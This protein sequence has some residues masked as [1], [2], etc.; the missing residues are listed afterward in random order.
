MSTEMM[1]TTIWR[2]M[3]WAI[4]LAAGS[5]IVTPAASG[6]SLGSRSPLGGYGAAGAGTMAATGGGPMIPYAG[7]FGGFMPYRM[8]GGASLF[9]ASRGT[10]ETGLTRTSFRLS[11]IGGGMTSMPVGI[12]QTFGAR[13]AT[14]SSFGAQPGT[15][16]GGALGEPMIGAGRPGVM[17]PSFAYPFYQPPSLVIPSAWGTG[18]SM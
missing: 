3:I 4:V 10:L 11:S 18:T 13:S 5:A 2:L 8:G 7:A 9:F 14:L 15:R 17:P 6:Q 16:L 1:Q 12:G